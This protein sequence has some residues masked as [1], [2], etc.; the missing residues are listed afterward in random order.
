MDIFLTHIIFLLDLQEF[1]THF[2]DIKHLHNNFY[3]VDTL[4][5]IFLPYGYEYYSWQ[6]N[7][8][9]NMTAFLVFS[10]ENDMGNSD[11]SMVWIIL[12]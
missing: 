5:H 10:Y 6:R 3:F 12:W 4:N 9:K 7:D 8:I 11:K 2:P 1:F